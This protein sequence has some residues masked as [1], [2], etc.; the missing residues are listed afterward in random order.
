MFLIVE[1]LVDKCPGCQVAAGVKKLYLSAK[2][3][4]NNWEVAKKK[5]AETVSCHISIAYLPEKDQS[6]QYLVSYETTDFLT[7]TTCSAI[8]RD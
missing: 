2:E 8:I 7:Q 1:D 6:E 5:V 3:A 4:T